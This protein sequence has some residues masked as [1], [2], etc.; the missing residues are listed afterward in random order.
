LR[1]G[2]F[3]DFGSQ[4]DLPTFKDPGEWYESSFLLYNQ[5]KHFVD[6]C[7]I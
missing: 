6:A 5:L 2:K 7:V 3:H 4:L 1:D